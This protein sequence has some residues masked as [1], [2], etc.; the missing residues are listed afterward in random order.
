MLS[1]LVFS[2]DRL[3]LFALAVVCLVAAGVV[4]GL[5]SRR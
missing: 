4:Q 5:S 3:Q 2:G 1:A